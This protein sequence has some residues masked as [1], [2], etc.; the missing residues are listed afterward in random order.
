MAFLSEVLEQEM[1]VTSRPRG[2]SSLA[3][4]RFLPTSGYRAAPR[5]T[6]KSY[7]QHLNSP[8]MCKPP[9]K[10]GKSLNGTV[11]SK[12]PPA[13]GTCWG[14]DGLDGLPPP[15]YGQHQPGPRAVNSVLFHPRRMKQ[16]SQATFPSEPNTICN[17]LC[18]SLQGPRLV[19][20]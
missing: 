7:P 13:S 16:S 4:A 3:H 2:L 5:L 18:F 11:I 19:W 20:H 12:R 6:L 9:G 1:M 17:E 14:G 15:L 10:P 8:E